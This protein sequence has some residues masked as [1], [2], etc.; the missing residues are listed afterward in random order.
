MEETGTT[1]QISHTRTKTRAQLNRNSSKQEPLS[2]R[3]ATAETEDSEDL[4]GSAEGNLGAENRGG[5]KMKK[6]LATRY[7]H[8]LKQEPWSRTELGARTKTPSRR[9]WPKHETED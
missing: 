8:Q 6:G 2:P 7:G 1:Q 3:L 4:T 9:Q 5:E